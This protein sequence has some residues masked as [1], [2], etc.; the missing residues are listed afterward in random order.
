[1]SIAAVRRRA[2]QPEAAH[3]LPGPERRAVQA[4][5]LLGDA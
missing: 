2:S 5:R 4:V 3:G 1:M